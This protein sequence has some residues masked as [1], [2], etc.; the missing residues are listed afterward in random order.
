MIAVC[1]IRPYSS[2]RSRQV[3][4]AL[5]ASVLAMALAGTAAAEHPLFADGK[6]QWKAMRYPE[7]KKNLSAYRKLPYARNI[8][9]DYML[10]S[11]DCRMGLRAEG[12]NRLSGMAKRYDLSPNV[13]KL[14]ASEI[15]KCRNA[16]SI[17]ADIA[18]ANKGIA[19]VWV[20]GKEASYFRESPSKTKQ[21]VAYTPRS[22]GATDIAAMQARLVPVGSEPEMAENLKR[23]A[24]AGARIKLDG[25]YALVSMAGQTDA[26]LA[27]IA[28]RMNAY[29]D[30]LGRQYGVLP[31]ESYMTVYLAANN[32]QLRN[33]AKTQHNLDISPNTLGYSYPHDQSVAAVESGTLT[34]SLQHELFHMLVRSNFGDIPLWLDEGIAEL[35]EQT[36]VTD[37][38]GSFVGV[39]NWRGSNV[40]AK[41]WLYRPLLADV[42]A[43]PWTVSDSILST[44]SGDT[45]MSSSNSAASNFAVARY[46]ALWLQDTGKLTAVYD[47]VK[48]IELDQSPDPAAAERAAVESVIGPLDEAQEKFDRWFISMHPEAGA[49]PRNQ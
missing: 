23:L 15:M 42:I 47:A 13:Q 5:C 4:G 49:I 35:Y 1:P 41:Q 10:G 6:K 37:A 3:A 45:P 29:L 25:N 39:R 2:R 40:L 18:D 33:V 48:A 26:Q 7:S 19:G 11:G 30:F 14:I 20:R 24:P 21:P 44:E 46:F 36:N 28:A 32:T 38:A 9:V 17:P 22:M 16:D 8:D 43:R 27:V 31:P 12:T 34:G